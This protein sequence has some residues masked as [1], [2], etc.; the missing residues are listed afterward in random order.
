MLL[1]PLISRSRRMVITGQCPSRIC[2]TSTIGNKD[3]QASAI[4]SSTQATPPNVALRLMPLGGS[5]T[6][7]VGSS[8]GNGYR[9]FLQDLLLANGYEVSMVGSRKA[10]SMHNN[11][12]EGWRGYRL[13]QIESKA[14]RSVATVKPN[15]F[16]INAGSND[17][18][19]NYQLD[20]FRERMDNLLEHLWKT[21]PLSTVILSTLL[22]NVD[23][24]VNSRVLDINSYLRELVVLK[25]AERKKI[26]LADMYSTKGP[27]LDDLMDGTHPN[28]DGYNKMAHIWFNAIQKARA[29]GFVG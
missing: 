29:N 25:E 22:V 20:V 17:C 15:L 11:E 23:K 19:Q 7:G 16:T 21:S 2:V 27:D 26:V 9:K 1:R 10:G 13:D 14:R 8:D 28:D 24:Q 4:R 5:V 18:I 12:N 6:Y 3:D